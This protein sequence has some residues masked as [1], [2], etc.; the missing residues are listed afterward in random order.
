MMS[1]V[2]SLVRH[3]PDENDTLKT[4]A[5]QTVCISSVIVHRNIWI[6]TLGKQPP[7]KETIFYS[8]RNLSF[9]FTLFDTAFNYSSALFWSLAGMN[10]F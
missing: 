5:Q 4:K 8:F 9:F 3:K 1:I 7:H 2:E 6:Q 10:G